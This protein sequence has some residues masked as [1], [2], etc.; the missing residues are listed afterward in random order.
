MYTHAR[1]LAV[2]LSILAFDPRII[3]VP[4]IHPL[5]DLAS[6]ESAPFPTDRFTAY[7]SPFHLKFPA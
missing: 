7:R 2:V 3:V 5:F 4:A 6:V 1:Y